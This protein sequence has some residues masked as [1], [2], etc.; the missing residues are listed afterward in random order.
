VVGAVCA[1]DRGSDPSTLQASP[2]VGNVDVYWMSGVTQNSRA[3][4]GMLGLHDN[5][6]Y[7]LI[8]DD[9][10]D[11]Q[12]FKMREY[13][14]NCK[15]VRAVIYTGSY[16]EANQKGD[17]HYLHIDVEP[18]VI[19]QEL[20]EQ[21]TYIGTITSTD[22]SNC[23]GWVEISPGVWYW[24]PHLHQSARITSETPFYSN[25]LV[26]PSQGDVWE[27]AIFWGS[28]SADYD[29]DAFSNATEIY[30]GTDL[31]DNCPDGSWD[32]AWPLDINKDRF[33]TMADV[34]MYAGRLGATPGA[35][36]YW[37]RVDL[38]TDGYITMADVLLYAG[39]IGTTCL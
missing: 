9:S 15:G 24:P 19:D 28:G 33:A 23:P 27:H 36:N 26:N 4:I 39:K 25:K 11:F 5:N 13:V 2:G 38:N 20:T 32:D 8:A 31:Y 7:D 29:S 34:N 22:K 21:T 16:N 6:A 1:S 37:Q 14:G 35:P 18:S 3:C 30:I 12:L 17:L 10:G